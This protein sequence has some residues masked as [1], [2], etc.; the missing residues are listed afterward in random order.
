MVIIKI[1]GGLGN[2]MF[3]YAYGNVLSIKSNEALFLDLTWYGKREVKVTDRKFLLNEMCV[4]LFPCT[5]SRA[6]MK[7]LR[8]FKQPLLG[9]W[10]SPSYFFE[11]EDLLR[12][13]FLL[14]NPSKAF[15]EYAR[16][17]GPGS[18]SVHVRRGDILVPH[19]KHLSDLQYY[20][21]AV[22]AIVQRQGLKNPAITIFSDDPTW[23][24]K[25]MT[26]LAGFRTRIFTGGLRSDAEEL[27][28][29]SKHENNVTA[30]STFS[31]WATMLN[32]DPKKVVTMPAKWLTDPEQNREHLLRILVP[33]W[34]VI[35]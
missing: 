3:Q 14:K 35:E 34:V 20:H 28:L 31:W 7:L 26:S 10:E 13:R 6:V 21:Q 5:G 29:I 2:Q 17:I 16:A 19:G 11:A 24:Q 25:K 15:E 9:Y 18:I 27:M 32:S 23:C 22:E 33:G 8:A 4:P 12:K 1:T 30:N